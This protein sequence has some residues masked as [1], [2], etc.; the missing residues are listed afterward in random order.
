MALSVNTNLRSMEAQRATALSESSLAVAMQRLSSGLRV[1][2]AADDAAGLAIGVRMDA[3][4]HGMGVALKNA[5]DGVSLLQTADAAYSS[6]TEVAQRMR[7]L[8]L[9]AFNGGTSGS[10]V[11][12]LQTEFDALFAEV[13]RTSRNTM[14]NGM[15]LLL[16]VGTWTLQVGANAAD[17]MDIRTAPLYWTAHAPPQVNSQ[18]ALGVVDAFLRASGV[19]SAMCGAGMNRL[20]AAIDNLQAGTACGSA[21]R[22]RILDADFATE[23][24]SLAR[25]QILQSAGNAMVAQANQ[26]PRQVLALLLR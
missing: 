17:T 9:Q 15:T 14:F 6:S 1:N 20:S 4:V 16:G 24:A 7:E 19:A 25:S 21:A 8:V 22:S 23:T 26:Q 2:S 12:N 13:D 18:G 10:D 3:Q 11:A 5:N